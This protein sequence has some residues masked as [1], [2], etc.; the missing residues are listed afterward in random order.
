MLS[1]SKVDGT[2]KARLRSWGAHLRPLLSPDRPSRL[3]PRA[4]FP[5]PASAI[6]AAARALF[7]LPPSL[8][9]PDW[10]AA[11]LFLPSRPADSAPCRPSL[12]KLLPLC[13][14]ASLRLLH[15]H[16]APKSRPTTH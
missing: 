2:A 1:C 16:C 9:S 5:R 13:L 12:E 6:A 4:A 7:L 10:P 11:L 15:D 3:R 14:L 8:A